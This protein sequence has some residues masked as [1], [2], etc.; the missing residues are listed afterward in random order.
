MYTVYAH[1]NKKNSKLYIGITSQDPEQRWHLGKH[2]EGTVFEKAI[3]KYGWDGFK[4]IILKS[5]LTKE[6]ACE[7]EKKLIRCLRTQDRRFGYNVSAGGEA[8]ATGLTWSWSEESRAR[9]SNQN[10]GNQ[11][12]AMEVEVYDLNGNLLATYPSG[13][14]A[15]E[16]LG[17]N[18]DSVYRVARGKYKQ[19]KGYV[20]KY[21]E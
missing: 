20:F 16:Q 21:K 14:I 12:R 18:L 5:E 4:H 13:K 9:R 19:T 10:K 8:P 6:E 3:K 11:F 15:A 17:I 7:L 1:K 2:Y